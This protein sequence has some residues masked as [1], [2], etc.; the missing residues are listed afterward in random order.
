MNNTWYQKAYAK[1]SISWYMRSQIAYISKNLLGE[2][3]KQPNNYISTTQKDLLNSGYIG[4]FFTSEIYIS[5]KD[6][7]KEPYSAQTD[8]PP[9]FK[10]ISTNSPKIKFSESFSGPLLSSV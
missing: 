4:S 2:I 6:V 1:F 5:S 9:A 7:F 8:Y 3:P 10:V